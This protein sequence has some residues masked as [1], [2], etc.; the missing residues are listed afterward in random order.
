MAALCAIVG[1][2]GC[3]WCEEEWFVEDLVCE[4]LGSCF[5]IV[6]MSLGE[7]LMG[8]VREVVILLV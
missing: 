7:E 1:W 6:R 4:D 2:V 5:W 3:G 8:W